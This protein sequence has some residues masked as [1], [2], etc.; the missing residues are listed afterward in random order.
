MVDKENVRISYLEERLPASL[1]LRVHWS[2][3]VAI[4]KITSSAADFVK[5]YGDK[6]PIGRNYKKAVQT[7]LMIKK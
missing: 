2:F 1:F 4:D 3:I 6:I 5:I 7:K